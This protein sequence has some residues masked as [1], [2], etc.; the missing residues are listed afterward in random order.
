MYIFY[1]AACLEKKKKKKLDIWE[2]IIAKCPFNF[3]YLKHSNLAVRVL[4]CSK[5]FLAL[6]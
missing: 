2:D 4:H 5:L 6:S 1:L 3:M